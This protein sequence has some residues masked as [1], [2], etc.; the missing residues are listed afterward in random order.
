M[1]DLLSPHARSVLLGDRQC[2]A[3]ARNGERC[4]RAPIPGGT[5]CVLHGGRTP[6]AQQAATEFM[7]SLREPALG[8]LYRATRNAPPCEHCGRSDADRDPVALKAAIA[9]LDRTGFHPSLAV[10]VTH[11]EPHA[12]YVAWIPQDRLEQMNAW[13]ADAKA[14]MANGEPQVDDV[15]EALAAPVE[16]AMLVEPEPGS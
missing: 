2:T 5:V 3:T 13:I 14:A 12:D 8:V 4:R 16:D 15:I 9:I 10:Q 7:A 11:E 6:L 1:N